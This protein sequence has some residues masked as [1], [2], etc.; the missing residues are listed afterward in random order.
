MVNIPR[1]PEGGDRRE[2]LLAI[3]ARLFVEQG[4]EATTLDQIAHE[5][6]IRKASIYYYVSSKEELLEAVLW[7]SFA[8]MNGMIDSVRFADGGSPTEILH[9]VLRSHTRSIA[10]DPIPTA[11]FYRAFN[12]LSDVRRKAVLKKREEYER[13]IRDLIR[14]CVDSGEFPEN[15]DSI[16]ASRAVLGMLNSVFIWYKPGGKL[17]ASALADRYASYAMAML[18]GADSV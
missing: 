18:K 5:L 6:A 14:Q 8:T 9:E 17:K 13:L 15:T 4:Y 2:E 7:K 12:G 1:K 3:A 11:V 10:L 16:I